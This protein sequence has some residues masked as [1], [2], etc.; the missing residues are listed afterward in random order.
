[1][2]ADKRR[3][4]V[5]MFVCSASFLSTDRELSMSAEPCFWSVEMREERAREVSFS[6]SLFL[7]LAPFYP[8]HWHFKKRLWQM[9]YFILYLFS[10]TKNQPVR[11]YIQPEWPCFVVFQ[12][13]NVRFDPLFTLVGLA[14]QS[15]TPVWTNLNLVLIISVLWVTCEKHR[16]ISLSFDQ[17]CQ[18]ITLQA[19]VNRSTVVQKL[20]GVTE[21]FWQ[22]SWT[23]ALID[24]R[25][26]QPGEKFSCSFGTKFFVHMVDF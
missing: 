12:Q 21:C 7:S 6:Q 8:K 5:F 23:K 3:I 1:M 20:Y 18:L 25:R 22:K 4:F 24:R 14:T 10:G 15:D 2:A 11:L 9:Q 19:V 13:S 17:E 16:N 26:S